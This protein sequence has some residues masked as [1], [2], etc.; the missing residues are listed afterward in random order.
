MV[1][2]LIFVTLPDMCAQENVA[3]RIAPTAYSFAMQ[4]PP[5]TDVTIRIKP[6]QA[7][8]SD[9]KGTA[10]TPQ[11]ARSS[12]GDLVIE[13]SIRSNVIRETKAADGKAPP[14]VRYYAG[15][16]CAF[17]DP[18]KGLNVYRA[19]VD[20]EGFPPGLYQFPELI[21]AEPNKRKQDPVVK[22]GSPK[23]A[24][25]KDGEDILEVDALT[26]RPL[27]YIEG[28]RE[29]LYSYKEN[30][31]PIVLPEKLASTLQHVLSKQKK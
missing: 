1:A 18:R 11:F 15:E 17:D 13:R 19:G 23:I 29:W 28:S 16:W 20:N 24:I 7:D 10:N 25:Y 14:T 27:R 31:T 6:K 30:L 9:V 22:E 2:F 4:L 26:R 12:E 8:S 21:W 3:S 5:G